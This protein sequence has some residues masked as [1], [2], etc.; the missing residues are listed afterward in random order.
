MFPGALRDITLLPNASSPSSPSLLLFFLLFFPALSMNL[1][2]V[3]EARDIETWPQSRHPSLFLM[4]HLQR[5]QLRNFPS[6]V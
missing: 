6:T 3:R 1:H 4:P 2:K 5:H